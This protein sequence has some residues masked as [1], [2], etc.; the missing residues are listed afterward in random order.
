[1]RRSPIAV[2]ACVCAFAVCGLLTATG[3]ASAAAP[4]NGVETLRFTAANVTVAAV[5]LGPAGKSP[6]D[7]YVYEGEI[8]Q[9]A[10]RIGSIY[11][12]NTSIKLKGKRE[13]VQ[14]QLSYDFGGGDTI[15]VAG[16]SAYPGT[17]DH[18]FIVG[19]A[20]GRVVVGGTGI[21]SGARGNV[22]TTRQANDTYKHVVRLYP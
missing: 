3:A 17:G 22:T 5:D 10:K 14:G 20:F 8:R 18:G 6:G 21:Y 12:T 2:A 11:G 19:E 4:S 15:V 16:I 7:L 13:I 1:M 9:G